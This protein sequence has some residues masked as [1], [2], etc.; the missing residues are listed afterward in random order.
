MVY[1]I[2][3]SV[4][5]EFFTRGI[6]AKSECMQITGTLVCPNRPILAG[7]LQIDLIDEDPLPWEVDDQMGRTWSQ[8][9]GSFLLSGCGADFGPFNS[10]DPYIVVEHK[11][12]SILHSSIKYQNRTKMQFALTKTFLPKVLNIG[13]ELRYLL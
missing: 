6:V 3:A 10:P 9:N 13:K 5:L 8:S 11:C 12:P 1:L 2:I 7:N 4:L